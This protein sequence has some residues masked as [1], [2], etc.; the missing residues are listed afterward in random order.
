MRLGLAPKSTK[1]IKEKLLKSRCNK[2]GQKYLQNHKNG[3]HCSSRLEKF[4]PIRTAILMQIKSLQGVETIQTSSRTLEDR[5]D[6]SL[7]SSLV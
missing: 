7:L 5:E 4:Q 6:L 3:K 1:G 2:S